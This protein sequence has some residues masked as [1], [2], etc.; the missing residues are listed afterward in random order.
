[1]DFATLDPFP[2]RASIREPCTI[3]RSSQLAVYN[4]KTQWLDSLELNLAFDGSLTIE[5]AGAPTEATVS[6]KQKII[7][8]VTEKAP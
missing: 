8:K 4:K 6:M 3:A 1:V 2:G 5:S 7:T